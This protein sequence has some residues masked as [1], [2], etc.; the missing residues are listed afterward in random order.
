MLVII[1]LILL[2]LVAACYFFST[3]GRLRIAWLQAPTL[4]KYQSGNAQPFMVEESV[5]RAIIEH[6]KAGE[7]GE[8]GKIGVIALDDGRQL[9]KQVIAWQRTP[10]DGGIRVLCCKTQSSL[11]E[12]LRPIHPRANDPDD[13]RLLEI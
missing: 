8:N 4:A 10:P 12:A 13:P 11:A 3:P 2:V 1:G 6:V 9:L 5:L 7:Y